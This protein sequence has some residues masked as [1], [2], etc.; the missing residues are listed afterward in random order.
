MIG[1]PFRVLPMMMIFAFGLRASISVASI[2][3]QV[4]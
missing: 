4:R 1:N 2:D 3:F